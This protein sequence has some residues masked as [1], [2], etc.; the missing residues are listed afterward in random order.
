MQEIVSYNLVLSKETILCIYYDTH[1]SGSVLRNVSTST[2]QPF[3]GPVQY[4]TMTK[5]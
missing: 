1:D 5:I 4:P 2:C 3:K